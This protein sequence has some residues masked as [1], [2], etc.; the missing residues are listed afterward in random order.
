MSDPTATEPTNFV[1]RGPLTNGTGDE[2]ALLLDELAGKGSLVVDLAAVPSVATTVVV[3]L[4]DLARR[5]ESAGQRLVLRNARHLPEL[6]L[7]GIS[8]CIE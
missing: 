8:H 6:C 7:D 1:M 2:F 4:I 5:I 3:A